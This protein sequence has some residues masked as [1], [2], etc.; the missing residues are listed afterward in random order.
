M[1][2]PEKKSFLHSNPG[3]ACDIR[4]EEDAKELVDLKWHYPQRLHEV[5]HIKFLSKIVLT[6]QLHD[7]FITCSP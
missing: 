3:K 6:L 2:D 4:Q 7:P 1:Y 5:E